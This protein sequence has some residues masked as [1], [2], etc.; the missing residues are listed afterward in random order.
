M[1]HFCQQ[2]LAGSVKAQHPQ[3]RRRSRVVSFANAQVGT[4]H[5]A[6]NAS[7][8]VPLG[9][10]GRVQFLQAGGALSSPSQSVLQ[11][12]GHIV[13]GGPVRCFHTAQYR[14]HRPLAVLYTVNCLCRESGANR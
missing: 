2:R 6:A 10:Y 3:V 8:G 5:N 12:V 4:Q 11:S 9:L 7:V 13:N 14:Q 1:L